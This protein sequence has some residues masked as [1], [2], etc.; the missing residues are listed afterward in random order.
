MGHSP[1]PQGVYSMTTT[2]SESITAEKRSEKSQ[3]SPQPHGAQGRR[4][5]REARG[6]TAEAGM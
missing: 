5:V 4:L 2:P 1:C 3:A 6:L